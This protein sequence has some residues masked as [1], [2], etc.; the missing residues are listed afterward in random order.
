MRFLTIDTYLP[1]PS[2]PVDNRVTPVS[3]GDLKDHLRIEHE[4]QDRLLLTKIMAATYEV[5]AYL[6]A[7]VIRR[8]FTLRLPRF[9]SVA[10]D[11]GA[12]I[13]IVNPPLVSVTSIS[14]LDENEALQIVPSVDYRIAKS[15]LYP[16]IIPATGVYWPSTLEVDDAVTIEYI[17]GWGSRPSE[18]PF[19]LREAIIIRA[20]SRVEMPVE[21]GVGAST[22][23]IDE[24]LSVKEILNPFVRRRV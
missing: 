15:G 20:G 24:D 14:Y 3:L 6:E 1:E 17:A 10:L 7:P 12:E 18:V 19:G 11:G 9:P 8:E 13:P 16:K 21:N 23:S 22:W 2:S 4:D 5:E